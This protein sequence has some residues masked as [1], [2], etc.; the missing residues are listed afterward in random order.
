VTQLT[1]LINAPGLLPSERAWMLRHVW[2]LR[3]LR[4]RVTGLQAA[5][6]LVSRDHP[7]LERGSAAFLTAMERR[8]WPPGSGSGGGL[9]QAA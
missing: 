8:L 1:A 2:R 6:Y 9:Q 3:L 7:D 5:F 4:D